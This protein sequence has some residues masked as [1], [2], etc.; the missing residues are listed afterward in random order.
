MLYYRVK[1]TYQALLPHEMSLMTYQGPTPSMD[2]FSAYMQAEQ[3]LNNDFNRVVC[4]YERCIAVHPLNQTVW[5]EYTKFMDA[6]QMSKV[7]LSKFRTDIR[8][9]RSQNRPIENYSQHWLA[10][11]WFTSCEL[12]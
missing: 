11:A 7:S 8:Q 6:A 5:L 3:Q 10:L 1:L 12:K 2:I 9:C 4:L